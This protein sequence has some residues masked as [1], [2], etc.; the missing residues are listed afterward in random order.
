[1]RKHTMPFLLI[2]FFALESKCENTKNIS[3]GKKKI[4]IYLPVVSKMAVIKFS[5]ATRILPIKVL[6]SSVVL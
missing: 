4:G 6:C 3:Y 1:M 2:A 5:R